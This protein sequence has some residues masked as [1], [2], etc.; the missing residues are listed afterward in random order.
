MDT[1]NAHKYFACLTVV[2]F[3]L[4]MITGLVMTQDH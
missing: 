2:C 1:F 4:T 3:A